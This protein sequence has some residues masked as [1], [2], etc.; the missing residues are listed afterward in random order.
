MVGSE[1]FIEVFVDTPLA[2][3][4]R[5]DV[6]GFYA[7]A[8]AGELHGFTGVDDPYEAPAAPEITLTTTDSAPEESAHRIVR[9]L[10]ERGFLAPQTS[11]ARLQDGCQ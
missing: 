3:C 6:K 5:R 7:R 1:R 9:Y 10:T 2:V 8:R 11:S 4:E